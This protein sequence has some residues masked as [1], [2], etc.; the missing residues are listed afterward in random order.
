M[1]S[2]TGLPALMAAMARS[3]STSCCSMLCTESLEH[4]ACGRRCDIH[5]AQLLRCAGD[6]M[7]EESRPA[8][9]RRHCRELLASD[10]DRSEAVAGENRKLLK[11]S[12][13]RQSGSN[14]TRTATTGGP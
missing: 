12:S 4:V 10:A 2:A 6:G 8:V 5:A 3:M 14:E 13:S 9:A 1:D 7:V 11:T